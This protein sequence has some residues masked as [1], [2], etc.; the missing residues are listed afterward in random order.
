MTRS[1]R[2]GPIKRLADDKERDAGSALAR[3]KRGLEDHER[4]LAQL[5]QYRAEYAARV[6]TGA[7]PDGVRLQNYHAFLARLGD[8]IAQQERAV[9]EAMAQVERA[10][11]SWRES[12]IEAVSIGRAV[13]KLAV[14]ERRAIDQRQ[15]R[16]TDERAL[17]R[18]PVGRETY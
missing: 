13:D 3:A 8:A 17:Q 12:R 18:R 14:A 15:Q 2:M 1:E 4:Q 9:T 6:S 11:E 16:E 10:T 7:A 5:R